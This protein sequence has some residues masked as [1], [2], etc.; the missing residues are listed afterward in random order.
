MINL[1]KKR[2]SNPETPEF[3]LLSGKTEKSSHPE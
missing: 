3:E 1:H 2:V